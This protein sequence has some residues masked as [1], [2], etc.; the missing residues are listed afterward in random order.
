MRTL[1]T[2]KFSSLLAVVALS[3]CRIEK[4]ATVVPPPPSVETFTAS[5]AQVAPGD[6]VTLSWKTANATSIEL[7]EASG[8]ALAVPTTTLEGT[9]VATIDAASLFVLVAR[10]PGGSD[11]RAVSVG[12]SGQVV[13]ELSFQ[14]LPPVIAGGAS[15]TLAWTAPGASL[16]TLTAGTQMVDIAG[17]RTS[18]AVTVSPAFDTTYTLT[19]DGVTKTVNV[20][21]QPA[22]LSADASPRAAEV[23]DTVTLS[24]TAAGADRVVVSANGRGQLFEATTPAQIQS[25]TFADVVPPTP[26]DGVITYEVAAVKGTTRFT[27]TLEVFVGT[28]LAITR[29][30]APAFASAGASY[31]VRWETRAADQVELKLDGVT[32]HQ[33]PSRQ[34]AAVGIFAFVSPMADFS[35]E[36]I[37]TNA[38]GGR[39]SRVAQVDSVGVPTAATLTASPATVAVGQPVTLTFAS[40]E[41]RRAR[42]VDSLGQVVFSVTGQAAE[43]GTATVYPDVSTTFTLSADNTLGNPAVTATAAV[44]VTGATPTVTQFPPTAISGQNVQVTTAAPGALLYGFAHNQ[45]LPATQADF[46]DIS[47]TGTRVLETGS[48]VTSVTLPFTA[49]VGGQRRSGPLTV[50]RAGWLAWGA[51]LVVTAT[52]AATL[53]STT[54]PAG[55]IAPFWD[56]LTFTA[57]SGVY[58]QVVGEA[59]DQSLFVQWNRMQVG[60]NAATEVTFQAQVHQHGMVSFRYATMTLASGYTSFTI[61]VQDDTRLVG[62]RSVP[63]PAGNSALYFFSPVAPPA[64]VRVARGSSLGGYVKVGDVYSLVTQQ[65]GAYLIPNDIGLTEL[66]F[67]THAAVPNGQYLEV[68]NRTPA[69]LDLS[70]WE[71][72]APNAPTFFVPGGFM[73]QPNVATVIGVSTDPA[74]NDDAGVSL[75]WGASGFFLSQDAGSF[76]IG[77]ADAGAGFTYTGPADGGRGQGINVDPGPIVGTS[78]TPG[79]QACLAT[80]PYGSQTPAQLGTPGSDPGCGFAYSLQVIPSKFVDISDAGTPLLNGVAATE[81]PAPINLAPNVGDPAPVAF[82]VARPQVTMMGNGYLMWGTVAVSAWSNRTLASATNAGSVAVFW[83]D[84]D[85]PNPDSEM[86]WKHFAANEDPA[87]P[88][89]HWVFQWKAFSYWLTSPADNMNFELKLFESGVIEYHYGSMVSGSTSNYAAG[90]SATAWLENPAGTQALVISINQQL[91]RPNTA[92]RFVP[93]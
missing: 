73:L 29:L 80:T 66:M 26:N 42:I 50:S 17:Q 41:A 32:V 30:D 43:N 46:R 71:L 60:T 39:V 19:A 90:T 33:T 67:R 47:G 89:Q 22:V 61:G 23:S 8:G 91:I 64:E 34:T 48:E 58:V 40:T 6:T 14:A 63:A 81:Y 78:G 49:F 25:G 72:R 44:T 57:N 24:W 88:Q 74:E 11:A 52:N 84:L 65:A 83:D 7:R 87:T 2:L 75:A 76:T 4:P 69:A 21:V 20:V 45:V 68:I 16:V 28:G 55:L 18:G 10:G 77:T 13:G 38:R 93:R 56:D 53:P 82:G 86:Y 70:G 79:L 37:A 36:V 12:L 5:A 1:H 54:G 62:V 9:F 35:V 31:S 3:G 85:S 59:P 15:T 92:F 27:R 51:P